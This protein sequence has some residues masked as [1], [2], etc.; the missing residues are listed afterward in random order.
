MYDVYFH[1]PSS[2]TERVKTVGTLQKAKVVAAR[3]VLGHDLDHYAGIHC[4]DGRGLL[5]T[6]GNGRVELDEMEALNV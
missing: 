6:K 1:Y 3:F 4:P 2:N 5:V